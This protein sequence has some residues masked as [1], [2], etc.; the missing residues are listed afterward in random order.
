MP[1]FL[2]GSLALDVPIP[3]AHTPSGRGH[4]QLK[5]VN[6]GRFSRMGALAKT[7]VGWLVLLL[8]LALCGCTG[9]DNDRLARVGRKVMGRAEAL[10]GDADGRLSRGWQALRD[11]GEVSL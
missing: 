4:S 10:L 3:R 8:A 7:R 6:W 9:E 5:S 11:T 2:R 1:R